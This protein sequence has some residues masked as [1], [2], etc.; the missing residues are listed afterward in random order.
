MGG[1]E[2]PI[3]CQ[4]QEFR[5][6]ALPIQ[7]TKYAAVCAMTVLRKA[8][9]S[10]LTQYLHLHLVAIHAKVLW[11]AALFSSTPNYPYHLAQVHCSLSETGPDGRYLVQGMKIN[12]FQHQFLPY[13]TNH[14]PAKAS[15]QWG[16]HIKVSNAVQATS[17]FHNVTTRTARRPDCGKIQHL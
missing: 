8:L 7:D 13:I 15:R 14:L 3:E 2:K 5:A 10:Q 11:Y 4:K 17:Y 12:R 1:S 6:N 9:G 16:S